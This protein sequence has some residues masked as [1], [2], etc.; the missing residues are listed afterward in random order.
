MVLTE[1]KE[2]PFKNDAPSIKA[3]SISNVTKEYLIFDSDMYETNKGIRLD[4]LYTLANTNLDTN[5]RK[6]A[7]TNPL[8]PGSSFIGTTPESVYVSTSSIL[9]I[10]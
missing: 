7:G 10:M 5:A 4:L 6:V 8:G 1:D 3:E 2:D 9:S